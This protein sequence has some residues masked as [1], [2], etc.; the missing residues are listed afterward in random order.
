MS[1]LERTDAY[2]MV[3]RWPSMANWKWWCLKRSELGREVVEESDVGPRFP[4]CAKGGG[5]GL[6]CTERLKK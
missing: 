2:A 6:L 5:D 4:A 3:T 1:K